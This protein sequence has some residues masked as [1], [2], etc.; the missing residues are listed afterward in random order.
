MRHNEGKHSWQHRTKVQSPTILITP[1]QHTLK[2]VSFS[3]SF[4]LLV[5]ATSILLHV[6]KPI[7]PLYFFPKFILHNIHICSVLIFFQFFLSRSHL[8]Q[9]FLAVR[10]YPKNKIF[11]YFNFGLCKCFFCNFYCYI[12]SNLSDLEKYI[13]AYIGL[14]AVSGYHSAITI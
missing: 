4:T 12:K 14:N 6:L 7:S 9:N 10:L 1:Q 8:F 13:P 5:L 3:P 2:L 11:Q